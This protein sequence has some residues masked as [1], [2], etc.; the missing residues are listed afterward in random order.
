MIIVP[1][2]GDRA[3]RMWTTLFALATSSPAPWTLIGAH[4]VALHGWARGHDLIRASQDA[5]ILVNV[6]AVADATRAMSDALSDLGFVFDGATPD[7]VGHRFSL[8]GVSI[9]V[10]APEGTGERTTLRT[11]PPARTVRVPGG[12]QAL[13]RT[14]EVEVITR[15]S[16]G[17]IPVPDLLGALL[18]KVRAIQIDDAPHA[19]AEDVAFLLSLIEDP[20]ALVAHLSRSERGWLR[21]HARFADPRDRAY[22]RIGLAEDAALAYRRLVGTR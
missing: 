11:V 4:M 13:R 20:D 3:H 1:D 22:A 8:D 21:D 14:A 5:D 7:G 2:L 6:R 12:T 17:T 19:Q 9:D 15:D 18:I 10:L 16:I